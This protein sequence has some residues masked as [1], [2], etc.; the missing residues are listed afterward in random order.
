M[1]SLQG[2]LPPAIDVHTVYDRSI[3]IRAAI[4]D[5]IKTLLLAL[6]FVIMVIYLFLGKWADTLI[7]SLVLP[8]SVF[9][10]FAVMRVFNFTLDNLSVLALTLAIGFIVDDAVVVL[11]NIVRHVEAGETPLQAALEGSRQICFTIAS[12]TMSL[13]AVFLP[14][15]F[16]G[17]LI[18]KIF[19]EF[20]ITLTAIT[21]IS[22]LISLTLTP[23]LCSRFI[24][25]R[26]QKRKIAVGWRAG[27]RRLIRLCCNGIAKDCIPLLT[28]TSSS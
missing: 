2:E 14:I 17:G 8:M 1:K 20:A 12:M 6:F 9:G 11:E 24:P 23:M 5:A 3:P 27:L 16:M 19:S 10:T 21:L 15:L 4:G 7:P 26:G 18:G 13:I 28:M 25:P 22:G